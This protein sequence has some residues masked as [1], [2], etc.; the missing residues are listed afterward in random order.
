MF[1]AINKFACIT[2]LMLAIGCASSGHFGTAFLLATWPLFVGMV[3][4]TDSI[5]RYGV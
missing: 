2:L 1:K 4:L 5:K 3:S